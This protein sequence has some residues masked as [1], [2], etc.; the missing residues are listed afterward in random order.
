MQRAAEDA[1][2]VCLEAFH[3]IR[4]PIFKQVREL[5]TEGKVGS[6]RHV[7]VKYMVE[8]ASYDKRVRSKMHSPTPVAQD[9]RMRS[10]CG[11]GVT[12][13]LG[14]YCVAIIRAVTGEEPKVVKATAQRWKDDQDID[15]AMVCFMELPSGATAEFEC[16]FVAKEYGQPIHLKIAGS[17]ADL[18]AE[19]LFSSHKSNRILLEQWDDSGIVSTESVDDPDAKNTHDS[20]Y[21]Q[22]MAFIDEVRSQEKLSDVGKG[23]P[24]AYKSLG[25]TPSDSVRNMAVID[26]IYRAAGMKPRSTLFA[27]PAPYDHIGLSKL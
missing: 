7:S 27:P 18:Q 2:K 24:W 6:V 25:N 15:A 20:F 1:G 23:L 11:G 22:L 21:Y 19:G 17:S 14:C 26:D 8:L 5:V 12:M 16:S 10:E 13:D 3:A 9:Y 4:H